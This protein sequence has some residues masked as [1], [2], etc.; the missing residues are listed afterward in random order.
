VGLDDG[1][2][3][4]DVARGIGEGEGSGG[5]RRRRAELDHGA[6]ALGEPEQQR[7][8]GGAGRALER[9][10]VAGAGGVDERPR[11]EP[12]HPGRERA[13]PG[14]APGE[15]AGGHARHPSP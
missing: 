7:D 8:V 10:V 5:P 1:V 9:E 13:E 14:Q 12:R 15:R 2:E 11:V 6:P 4:A 3:R